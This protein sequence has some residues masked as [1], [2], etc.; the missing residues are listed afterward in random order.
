MWLS[1][2]TFVI[3][4][5]ISYLILYFVIKTAVRDAIIEARKINDTHGANNKDAAS[6]T[7]G[8]S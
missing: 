2:N 5:L 6:G 7:N 4:M 8:D 3:G 1:L